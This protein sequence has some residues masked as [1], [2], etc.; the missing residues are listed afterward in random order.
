MNKRQQNQISN[1]N[2]LNEYLEQFGAKVKDGEKYINSSTKLTILNKFNIEKNI[3]PYVIKRLKD[4]NEYWTF[5]GID[6]D[7]QKQEY[8]Q[9]KK[10]VE[11]KGGKIKEGQIYINKRTEM[12]FIDEY[13]CEFFT[14]PRTILDGYW[15]DSSTEYQFEQLKIIV[16]NNGWS[17]KAG[18]KY[19]NANTNMIFIDEKGLEFKMS[20]SRVKQGITNNKDPA[21]HFEKL[22]QLVESKGGKI[23]DGEK[24]INSRTKMTFI[25]EHNLEFTITPNDIIQ[26]YWNNG[27]G[28][29]EEICRQCIEYIFKKEFPTDW[30]IVKV[31][32][33]N[34]NNLQLDGYNKE[35]KIAFE[36]QGE[37]HYSYKYM[38][39]KNNIE[40]YKLF[41][42]QKERDLFK[43]QFCKNKG[44]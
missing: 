9:L 38:R 3:E 32:N 41:K 28:I 35:L 43:E 44:I 33:D 29:S 39:C 7:K 8:E 6:S 14:L 18:Q 1:L 10:I 25:D 15:R 42:K 2:N 19:I 31:N 11:S 30:S 21:Y 37:Q 26:G 36:Y 22:K 16:K 4:N 40:K 13:N 34:K 24:Y 20:P 5:D 17:I 27:K 23:K 12:I